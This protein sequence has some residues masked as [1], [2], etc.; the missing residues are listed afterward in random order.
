MLLFALALMSISTMEGNFRG[1]SNEL[2][3]SLIAAVGS[4]QDGDRTRPRWRTLDGC[5]RN[6]K[7]HY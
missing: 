2:V 4:P 3:L 5:R 1:N 6:I 7:G